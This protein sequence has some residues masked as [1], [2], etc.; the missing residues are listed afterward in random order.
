MGRPIRPFYAI[1]RRC[2]TRL[3]WKNPAKMGCYPGAIPH[4]LHLTWFITP[5]KTNMTLENHHFRQEIHLQMVELFIVMLVFRVGNVCYGPLLFI[6]QI[7]HLQGKCNVSY[8][9][10]KW[11]INIFSPAFIDII[12]WEGFRLYQTIFRGVSIPENAHP[13]IATSRDT[14]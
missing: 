4:G 10:K 8:P 7:Y 14:L 5:P 3:V 13:K 11:Q 12:F 9:T 2:A 1:H 6:Y